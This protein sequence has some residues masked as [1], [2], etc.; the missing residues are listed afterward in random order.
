MKVFFS[1]L[2]YSC[3]FIGTQEELEEHLKLCKFEGMKD[4]LQRTDE[5]VTDLQV[6]PASK[7]KD[8]FSFHFIFFLHFY[9]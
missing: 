3:D 5:R 9:L 1:T 7:L 6:P 8:E 4:F 2:F